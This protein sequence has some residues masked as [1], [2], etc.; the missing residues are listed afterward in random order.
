MPLELHNEKFNEIAEKGDNDNINQIFFL[1]DFTGTP[2]IFAC[3]TNNIELVEKLL[4]KGA[5]ANKNYI[6]KDRY[7]HIKKTETPLF[8]ACK[9]NNVELAKLLLEKGADAN[10]TY[11]T[12]TPLFL[13]CKTNNVELAKLLL[14]KGADANETY[15]TETPLFLA[16]KT[17]NIDLA[18]LLLEKGADVNYRL[19]EGN[20]YLHEACKNRYIEIAELLIEKGADLNIED[21]RSGRVPLHELCLVNEFT[22]AVMKII[23]LLIKKGA[24]IDF[25]DYSKR[26]PLFY[27]TSAGFIEAVKLLIENGADIDKTESNGETP[28]YCAVDNDH[29]EIVKLLTEN[30]ADVNV[31]YY[32]DVSED[33]S[34]D[35][36]EEYNRIE[37]TPLNKAVRENRIEIAKQL[38]LYVLLN[39]PREKP[40]YIT[41]SLSD[42]WDTTVSERSNVLKYF[43]KI[44]GC[45][46]VEFLSENV[47]KLTKRL[48]LKSLNEIVQAVEQ[49]EKKIPNPEAAVGEVENLSYA[50]LIKTRLEK[51]VERQKLLN[52]LLDKW[53]LTS[54]KNGKEFIFLPFIPH[55][56]I[57]EISRYL[58]TRD[59]QALLSLI[60]PE[61]ESIMTDSMI[62][63]H[64]IDSSH[65]KSSSLE[66]EDNKHSL[67]SLEEQ[68]KEN[69][70]MLEISKDNIESISNVMGSPS[71]SGL[72]ANRK[73]KQ[74][75][76]SN[77]DPEMNK[78]RR[79]EH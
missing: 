30:G 56:P 67:Q 65:I 55:I 79:L 7:S 46:I 76:S 8:L 72:F 71:S 70:S 21:K 63:N 16:C 64:A 25:L 17:N 36:I 45:S 57:W 11:K 54:L 1:N 43:P 40:D 35:E 14:E 66:Q 23:N 27:A 74:D 3:K 60:P 44:P 38:I 51:L 31:I 47:N 37:V 50:L 58:S 53:P 69:T 5:D 68:A 75:E 4:K 26:T 12:Q 18:K 32:E 2:L 61:S 42:F 52:N 73:R 9:T 62:Q 15:K 59:I 24:D 22:E 48:T 77:E 78:L 29:I 19:A 6:Y 41:D 13:A 20:S 28:L 33:E 10:K 34:D 39:N 49:E